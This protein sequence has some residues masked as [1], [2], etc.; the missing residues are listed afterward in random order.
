MRYRSLW[1]LVAVAVALLSFANW[2]GRAQVSA[3]K[4]WEYKV[5]VAQYGASPASLSEEDLNKLG[6]EGWELVE[7]R[8][9]EFPRG[10][11]GQYRTDYYFKR[12]R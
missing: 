5:V 12:L 2:G 4:N 7:T 1:V 3:R 8:S 9:L 10:A 6:A 11:G